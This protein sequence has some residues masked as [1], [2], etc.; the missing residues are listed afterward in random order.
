[1]API[2]L[3]S[4]GGRNLY[5]SYFFPISGRRPE[6]GSVSGKQDR[7]L[8]TT[9]PKH[10]SVGCFQ[11]GRLVATCGPCMNFTTF[12]TSQKNTGK[13]H[14]WTNASV[15]GN[16]RRTF[17]T[18][19]PYEFPQEKVWTND[20]SIWISPEIR[21]DQWRSKFSESFS[22]DRYWSIE[23]S[24]LKHFL[25][26]IWKIAFQRWSSNFEV[27]NHFKDDLA[28]SN[29]EKKKITLPQK[30]SG[31]RSLAK[32]VAKKVTKA[33]GKKV[34]E[35]WPKA[36]RKRKKWSNSFCR[37]PFA[38]PWEDLGSHEENAGNHVASGWT[39][40]SCSVLILV[41]PFLKTPNLSDCPRSDCMQR[42]RRRG[43][44]RCMSK[45][46][47]LRAERQAQAVGFESRLNALE[48]VVNLKGR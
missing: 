5:F 35:K 14:P 42:L 44:V 27:N 37:T 7:K 48:K 1:M 38:A 25:K 6:M 17:R 4:R 45:R 12:R 8:K 32:N 26:V 2:F 9:I 13:S 33:S 28:F 15:G 29:R 41:P 20:W 24:S 46:G 21:M 43:S 36:S 11:Y 10:L 30:E 19:G 40:M 3:F 47:A 23:C 22:L 34:T 18:I 16:F 31:K 39:H